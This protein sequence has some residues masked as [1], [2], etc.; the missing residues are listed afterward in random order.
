MTTR[1]RM[2]W[3]RQKQASPPPA[4]YGWTPD[5]PAFYPDPDA[6]KYE[7]GD[8][9]SW[10]E[11]P[12]KGPYPQGPA[13]ASVSWKPS[14]P[15]AKPD[16]G[17]PIPPPVGP[18]AGKKAALRQQVEK[19]A[20]KCIRIASAILGK[21]AST[22]AVENKALSLMDMSERKIDAALIK[23]RQ[24]F[25]MGN[26]MMPMGEDMDGDGID[27]NDPE[28]YDYTGMMDM[29]PP[30]VM[31]DAH[32]GMMPMHGDDEGD[33]AEEKMLK[34]MLEEQ[35]GGHDH[36]AD[37][38][39]AEMLE[40]EQAKE[41]AA[42][43][44]AMKMA[45][46]KTAKQL[47]AALSA[48]AMLQQQVATLKS[49]TKKAEE[50]EE[51]DPMGVEADDDDDAEAKKLASLFGMKSAKKVA[52][53]DDGEKK[54]EDKAEEE[55]M[56]K[57]LAKLLAK[58]DDDDDDDDGDEPS[59][60]EEGKSAKKQAS[61]K[62]L[63]A[64]LAA[65][66]A[67]LADDDDDDDDDDD[68]GE[69]KGEM[70]FAPKSEKQAYRSLFADDDKGDDDDDD[71]DGEEVEVEVEAEETEGKKASLRP[72]A[73]KASAGV[74]S[75]GAVRTASAAGGSDL[76]SLWKSAPDVSDHF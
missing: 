72:Q 33:S 58:A 59:E 56:A 26:P 29:E 19:K 23:L 35:E 37:D 41:E 49:A 34:A 57:K 30:P 43:E 21:E 64:K 31:A 20:A 74:K 16:A 15:A 68:K 6:D 61:K 5:H 39:L 71:D 13:P 51:K 75:L 17:G 55:K 45:Q 12:T 4:S 32:Y 28:T 50:K 46:D 22:E 1:N 76:S 62:E 14:H 53:D 65:L 60:S 40:Q 42:G 38:L 73:R 24:A 66:L 11:D 47:E 52:E 63:K 54:G 9:S 44:A 36:E 67:K 3:Q 2:T 10:A 25:L 70:P 27:Q 8:T 7:N 48:I 18:D 69:E